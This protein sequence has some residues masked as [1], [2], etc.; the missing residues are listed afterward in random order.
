LV[1]F[2]DE[3]KSKRVMASLKASGLLH[4]AG[5]ATSLINTGQQ[6]LVP[7]GNCG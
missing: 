4:A 6:W 5:I 1:R 3:A 7:A 2:A